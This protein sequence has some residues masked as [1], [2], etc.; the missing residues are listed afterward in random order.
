MHDAL[1]I[2]YYI[3]CKCKLKNIWITNFQLC[4]MLYFAQG[5][6]LVE[7]DRPL[8]FNDI[9]ALKYGPTVNDVYWKYCLYGAEK[10]HLP[11]YDYSSLIDLSRDE[12]NCINFVIDMFKDYDM[13]TLIKITTANNT[14]WSFVNKNETIPNVL[15][16]EYFELIKEAK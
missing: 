3:L 1:D 8:F 4:K 6:M 9:I 15:I 5:L 2:A 12:I 7:C 13:C 14:P 16:K 10:I 11:K